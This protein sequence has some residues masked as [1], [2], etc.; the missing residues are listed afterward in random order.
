MVLFQCS[1]CT[2]GAAGAALL[3]LLTL[4]LATGAGGGAVP[5]AP[6]VAQSGSWKGGMTSFCFKHLVCLLYQFSFCKRGLL[7]IS[8]LV[9][10]F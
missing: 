2:H 6:G 8:T 1:Q 4:A 7:S 9:A 5:E 10:L 3:P